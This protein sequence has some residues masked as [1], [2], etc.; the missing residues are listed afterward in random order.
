M[1]LLVAVSSSQFSYFRKCLR[2]R[3]I[4]SEVKPQLTQ[5]FYETIYV[6]KSE[7]LDYRLYTCANFTNLFRMD[8]KN[9]VKILEN[10]LKKIILIEVF[11]SS[12]RS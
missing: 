6:V 4:W 7:L 8:F 5:E 10:F 3:N 9:K 1:D 12:N 2:F 11:L